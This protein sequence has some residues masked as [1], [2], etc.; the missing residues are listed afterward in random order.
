MS[1]DQED[2]ATGP[3]TVTALRRRGWSDRG[4]A[5]ILACVAA[6]TGGGPR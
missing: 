1:A 5:R 3:G 2:A 6:A 4:W